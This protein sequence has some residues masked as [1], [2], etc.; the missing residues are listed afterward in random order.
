[1]T[2]PSSTAASISGPSLNLPPEFV[3]YESAINPNWKEV[4]NPI[5]AK[6]LNG[7]ILYRIW[8]YKSVDAGLYDQLVEDF[9]EIPLSL[10]SEISRLLMPHFKDFL[11]H[12]GVLVIILQRLIYE[13]IYDCVQAEYTDWPESEI[14][15]QQ[16]RGG[17][18]PNTRYGRG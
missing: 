13:R 9:R 7:F 16:L 4:E 6:D 10:W 14:E 2:T 8:G 17:F 18:H 1:M 15:R 12:R 3:Q 11:R 5:T